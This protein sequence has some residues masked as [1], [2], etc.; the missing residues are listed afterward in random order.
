M[1]K[2]TL[3]KILPIKISSVI[4]SGHTVISVDILYPLFTSHDLYVETLY[5]NTKEIYHMQTQEEN[6]HSIS[7]YP[8]V[9]MAQSLKTVF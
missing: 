9:L 4:T 8:Q 7:Q 1:G 2:T 3:F 6:G 5:I